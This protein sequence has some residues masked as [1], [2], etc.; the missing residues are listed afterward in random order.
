MTRSCSATG[1]STSA[2]AP[3]A[4]SAST[5]GGTTTR[6]CVVEEPL[7]VLALE[8]SGAF[9]GRYHV[10]HGA[11][12]PMDGIGPDRLR[13]RQ[14]LAAGRRAGARR[15]SVRGGG[16][17]HQPDA[18][19][20]GDRDVP[21][22]AARPATSAPSRASRAASPSA[23]TWSTPTR[24]PWSGRSRVAASSRRRANDELPH[25][26]SAAAAHQAAHRAGAGAHPVLDPHR[27]HG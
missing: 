17:R 9:R 24:S 18:G 3:S 5:P 11:I 15:R 25:Q 2:P 27:P 12:S 23:A 26:R 6:L 4:P 19:R 10:L 14:L 21:R 22:R 1:A 20:R 8:R 13:I 7:D 16:P